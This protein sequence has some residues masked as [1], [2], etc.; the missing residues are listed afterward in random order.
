MRACPKCLSII[1]YDTACKHMTCAVKECRYEFCF[2]CLE[3]WP[4]K[5]GVGNSAIC[6]PVQRQQL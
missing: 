5:N 2:S 6:Q 3:K 4:C 1:A